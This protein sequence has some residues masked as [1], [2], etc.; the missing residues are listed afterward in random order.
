[1]MNGPANVSS[2]DQSISAWTRRL[3]TRRA[4]SRMPPM[5]TAALAGATPAK[6]NAIKI[7]VAG[8]ARTSSTRLESTLGRG[9]SRRGADEL[10]AMQERDERR[11]NDQT[12]QRDRAQRQRELGCRRCE[13]RCRSRFPA[14]CR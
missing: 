1:M 10:L 4:S 7:R 14:G 2:S 8:N 11:D 9:A 5:M 13:R 6:K 12:D 3:F